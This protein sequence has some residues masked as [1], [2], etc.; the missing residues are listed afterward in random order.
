MKTFFDIQPPKNYPLIKPSTVNK[1][2]TRKK[3]F[4]DSL[5]FLILLFSLFSFVSAKAPSHSNFLAQ[6]TNQ[7]I[8]EKRQTL[9]TELQKVLQEIKYYQQEIE[10]LQQEKRSLTQEIRY[11]DSQIKKIQLELKAIS[12]EMD[13][14]EERIADTKKAISVTANK[15]DKSRDILGVL[16]RYYYQLRQRNFV[17]ILLTGAKISDYFEQVVA[18]SKLQ[19][20]INEELESLNNLRETL[21]QQ[22]QSL[23]N[24]LEEKS[25]LFS[26]TKIKESQLKDLKQEKNEVLA[27]KKQQETIYQS[28]LQEKQK[29]AAEI[30][31]QIYQLAGG[32]EIPFGE[33][34]QYAEFAGNMTDVRPALLLAILDY[35]SKIGKNVGNCSYKKAMKP[36][37]MPIF[38]K[39]TRELGLDPNKMP[40]S[41]KP[42]YGWGGAM[43]PA[44]FLPS[45]W[46]RYKDEIA[47]LTGDY[48]PSPWNIRDAFVAAALY[49]KNVGAD[50]KTYQAEW[51]AAM[52]Y[53]AGNNWQ[54]PSLRFYGD[55]VMALAQ[56]YQ[57]DIDFLRR[58]GG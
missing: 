27:V 38:E 29:T 40:V 52:I 32:G 44:Q 24:N 50:K 33:A 58:Q 2:K 42:W 12:L 46:L 36:S 51:K 31:A 54:K 48:P 1:T 57:G 28:K 7:S 56:K 22:K 16:I 34:L 43:G 21:K 14:L 6:Q 11:L 45:T 19:G 53:F 39:I 5:L 25:S 4:P 9:E 23:E 18:M 47:K 37:E 3:L 26:L 30:R 8:E 17:E 49:L 20:R 15:I 41:C 55:D 13:S 35:E 10:Y